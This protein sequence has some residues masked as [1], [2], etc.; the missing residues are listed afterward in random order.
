MK[1]FAHPANHT[2]IVCE[3]WASLSALLTDAESKP[4]L[5]GKDL[6]I[7]QIISVAR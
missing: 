1:E 6:T 5:T 2:D 7:A 4:V 3:E